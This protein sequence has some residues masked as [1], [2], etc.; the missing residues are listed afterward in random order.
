[1]LLTAHI[2]PSSLALK[3]IDEVRPGDIRAFVAEL[4]AKRRGDGPR[5]LGPCRINMARDRLYAIF[6]E[7]QSDG[8]VAD[9][10]VRHVRRLAEPTP[11][12]DPFTLEEV[13]RILAQARDQERAVFTLLL[14]TGMR[15]GEALGLRWDDVDFERNE[16]RVRRTLSRYGLGAPKTRGSVREV[17]MLPLV[18]ETLL[19][20]RARSMLAGGFVFVNER[21]GPLDETNLRERIWR[22]LLS[23]AGLRYRPLYHCRHTY[24]TLELANLEHPLFVSRQLG[25]STPETTFRRYARFMKRVPGTG[26]LAERLAKAELGQKRP[27]RGRRGGTRQRENQRICSKNWWSGRRG[28]NP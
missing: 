21:G 19:E 3:R 27:A 22:R 1:M 16:V 7:A 4:D 26:R 15:P 25:H 20:Q 5:K 11:E 12:V 2:L 18:R 24:A 13:A 23:R 9:N 10:P 14:L 17:E 6:S 8:L 28:S